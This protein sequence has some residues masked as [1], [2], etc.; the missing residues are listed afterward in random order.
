[1]DLALDP[2]R[3]ELFERRMGDHGPWMHDYRFG[4][5]LLTGYSKYEGVDGNLTFVNSRSPDADVTRLRDAYLGRRRGVWDGFVE[6]LFDRAEPSRSAR[7]A[8]HLLD[9]G[10]GTGQLS[11]RAVQAG[12]GR[13]TSAEIRPGQIEQQRLLLE[14]LADPVYRERLTPVQD[15]ISAD[16]PEFPDRYRAAPP[17]VVC[18]FGVLYHLTNPLQHL[19]NLHAITSDAAIVYT[20]THY[21]PLAKGM[22]YLTREGAGWVT[23]AVSSISWTPHFLEVAKLCRDVGFRSV[24]MCYPDLFRRRFPEMTGG[25]SRWTDVKLAAQMAVQRATGIRL[26]HLR[27]HDFEFFRDVNVNPNYV[28]YVCRK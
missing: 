15:P 14:C 2:D 8:M 1:M 25:Y 9:V 27:N 28:A 19:I 20:M 7:A 6:S 3:V 24:E 26:G 11:I 21:H 18:S 17:D 23:K 22:W 12:F 4:D 13:V 5:R 10:S 16:A